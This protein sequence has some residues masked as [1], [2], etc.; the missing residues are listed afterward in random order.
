MEKVPCMDGSSHGDY[1]FCILPDI[2]KACFLKLYNWNYF[3]SFVMIFVLAAF[4]RWV[5]LGVLNIEQNYEY[6]KDESRT[7]NDQLPRRRRE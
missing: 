2:N 4:S 7:P 1:L 3:Y 6:A 5:L